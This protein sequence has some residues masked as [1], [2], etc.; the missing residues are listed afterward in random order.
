M[1]HVAFVT[2]RKFPD[3]YDDDR[4]LIEPLRARGVESHPAVWNDPDV[5]WS[6][7]DLVVI[8]S[9]WDYFRHSVAFFAWLDHLEA[10]Q[11]PLCNPVSVVR[12]N[13]NKAYLIDLEQRGIKVVPSALIKAGSAANLETTLRERG[14]DRA[15]F[16]PTISAGAY[17]TERV[18]LATA[19]AGQA[20]FENVLAE[21][22]VL[23]QP[24]LEEIETRGEWSLLFFDKQFSHAVVKVPQSGDFRVQMQYG[25]T[26]V[27]R[28][29]SDSLLDQARAI[30]AAVDA[31]LLYARVDGVEI[32]GSLV[33][34]ELELIEPFL[35]MEYDAP[36]A[37]Q[38]CVNAI[39]SRL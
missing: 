10:G 6:A 14:W 20:Q 29:P 39:M 22:D 25:G 16:K 27:M 28:K 9:C 34:M 13:A 32:D 31:P 35:F 15:I 7:F 30:L 12:W 1:K 21:V 2:E 37:V 36:H 3:L 23:V 5:D 18:A 26:T 11:V 4:A 8:R 38:R 19:Q 33:L 17:Q 24:Y